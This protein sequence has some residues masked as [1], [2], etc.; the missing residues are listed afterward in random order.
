MRIGTNP[1]HIFELPDEIVNVAAKVR[2]I[3]CQNGGV[4]LTKDTEKIEGNQ[5]VFHLTQEETLRF[6]HREPVELQ[7][8]VLTVSGD[9]LTSNITMTSPYRCLESTVME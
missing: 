6:S 2:V 5:A 3:Y 1:M 8:R 7:L 4:V 9:A